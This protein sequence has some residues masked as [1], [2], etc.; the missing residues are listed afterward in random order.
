MHMFNL[1]RTDLAMELEGITESIDGV[2]YDRRDEDGIE[3]VC[4]SIETDEAEKK[5]SKPKG[6][7]VSIS[8]PDILYD[9]EIYEKTIEAVANV[10][11]EFGDTKKEV[12]VAGLGNSNITPDA[13]GP[14][15]VSRVLVTKHMKERLNYDFVDKLGSVSAIAPGVLGTTGIKTSQIIKAIVNEEKPGLIIAVDAYCAKSIDRISTT[16]QVS[17]T[18]IIPGGGVGNR[19]AAINYETMGVPVIAIG[20]PTVVDAVAVAASLLEDT[21]EDRIR[22]GLG[23]NGESLVV[24]PKDIDIII[25]RGAKT[26]ANA[27]NRA[28]NPQLSIED[29]ESFTS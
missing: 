1:N 16:I 8:A 28:F 2:T 11:K 12:L 10:I 17:D 13:L 14:E 24:T 23:K 21:S 7:Y 20:I 18:G 25:D 9:S 22:S 26:V 15:V 29:I 3:T 4:I 6:R 27:I 5:L 19:Q